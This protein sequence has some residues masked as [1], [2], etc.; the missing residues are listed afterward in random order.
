MATTTITLNNVAAADEIEQKDFVQIAD[1]SKGSYNELLY[2]RV[3]PTR[4]SIAQKI[5]KERYAL[6]TVVKDVNDDFWKLGKCSITEMKPVVNAIKSRISTPLDKVTFLFSNNNYWT[7]TIG[8]KIYTKF[9]GT[10]L[11]LRHFSDTRG[12]LWKFTLDDDPSTEVFIS[13]W[14]ATAAVKTTEVYN[15]IENKDYLVEAEFVGDDPN[16]PPTDTARGWFYYDTNINTINNTFFIYGDAIDVDTEVQI[17]NEFSNKEMAFRV[18]KAGSSNDTQWIPDHG[19]GT[20]FGTTEL[21]AD[22]ISFSNMIAIMDGFLPCNIVTL[23][24]DMIGKNT[25]DDEDLMDVKTF[26]VFNSKNVELNCYFKTITDV[27]CVFGYV[28]MIP[29]NIQTFGTLM[30][31]SRMN[32]YDLSLTSGLTYAPYKENLKSVAVIDDNSDYFLAATFNGNLDTFLKNRTNYRVF[33]GGF[34]SR[35]WMEHRDA[36]LN[37]FYPQTYSDDTINPDFI[38]Q[39]QMTLS[40]GNLAN[41][42]DLFKKPI[43]TN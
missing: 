40:V 24:N 16:N 9:N 17:L 26:L 31:D 15:G 42:F 11:E 7:T 29:I 37:K 23:S 25:L 10:K 41:A 36:T 38:H 28:N 33:S 1:N 3:T 4:L 27:Y 8:D 13:V 22:D 30:V 19:V 43:V 12:G 21:A 32:S 34:V 2:K 35:F 6:W 20:T 5:N 39:T 14:N 18:R